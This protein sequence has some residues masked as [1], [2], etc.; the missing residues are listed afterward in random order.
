M[1]QELGVTKIGEFEHRSILAGDFQRVTQQVTLSTDADLKLGSVLK[2]NGDGT[3]SL[4]DDA[5]EKVYG[6][7]AQDVAAGGTGVCWLTGEFIRDRLIFGGTTTWAD[8]EDSARQVSIFFKNA[9]LL[10]NG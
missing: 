6:V 2:K 5:D 3:V 1:T 8:Y 7:L 10:P 4:I 9:A